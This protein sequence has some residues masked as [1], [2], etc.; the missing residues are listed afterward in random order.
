VT[1]LIA[2]TRTAAERRVQQAGT[3]KPHLKPQK[4]KN[5][6]RRFIIRKGN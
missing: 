6:K 2:E 1:A 3:D 4:A 5:Y